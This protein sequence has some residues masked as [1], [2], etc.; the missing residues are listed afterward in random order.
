MVRRSMFNQ[1][2]KEIQNVRMRLDCLENNLSRWNSPPVEVS[3]TKLI[4][5]PD[6]LRKTYLA[7]LTKGECT[8]TRVSDITTRSRA[9][10][11]NYLNQL[12]RMGWLN[13]RRLEKTTNFR[14]ATERTLQ[15][16][17]LTNQK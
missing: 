8:A 4:S 12:V 6:H 5:L 3:E 17:L 13:K 15:R 9:I 1:I 2:L 10:E 11:S 7:V 14:S 16:A